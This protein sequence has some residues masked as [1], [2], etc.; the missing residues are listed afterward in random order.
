MPPT[1]HPRGLLARTR[2]ARRRRTLDKR[3]LRAEFELKQP[4]GFRARLRAYAESV[5]DLERARVHAGLWALRPRAAVPV[6]ER[7]TAGASP[8]HCA[9][10]PPDVRA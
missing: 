7:T 1:S 2:A 6:R 3:A 10:R 8:P 5:E 4:R 9:R